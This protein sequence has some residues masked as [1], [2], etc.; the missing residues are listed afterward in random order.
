MVWWDRFSRNMFD[1]GIMNNSAT[2]KYAPFGTNYTPNVRMK[3]VGGKHVYVLENASSEDESPRKL[4][5]KESPK[6]SETT[7]T[8]TPPVVAPPVQKDTQSDEIKPP[9]ARRVVS[10]QS[11]A[12]DVPKLKLAAKEQSDEPDITS[13]RKP[14]YSSAQPIFYSV[15]TPRSDYANSH[16]HDYTGTKLH[17]GILNQNSVLPPIST[18]SPTYQPMSEVLRQENG[19]GSEAVCHGPNRAYTPSI[20]DQIPDETDLYHLLPRDRYLPKEPIVLNKGEELRLAEL[21]HRELHRIDRQKLK[22]IYIDLTHGDGRLTGFVP[23]ENLSMAFTKNQVYVNPRLLRLLGSMFLNPKERSSINYEKVLSY[24]DGG[25]KYSNPMAYRQEG[26]SPGTNRSRNGNQ[27]PLPPYAW[28]ANPNHPP[29]PEGLLH[30]GHGYYKVDPPYGQHT[31]S[32]LPPIRDRED[33]KLRR[34]VESQLVNNMNFDIEHLRQAVIEADRYCRGTLSAQQMKDISWMCGLPLQ[35]NILDRIINRCDHK[36]L[37][38]YVW[39]Q[40]LDYIEKVT[41]TRTGMFIP[42]SKRPLEYAI[43]RPTPG[44]NWPLPEGVAP[45]HSHRG[46]EIKVPREEPKKAKSVSPPLPTPPAPPAQPF[47]PPIDIGRQKRIDELEHQLKQLES[48][49]TELKKNV[50]NERKANN[51]KREQIRQQMID[52]LE[53]QIGDLD[54]KYQDLKKEQ[55]Q[56]LA[57][58]QVKKQHDL[59][60][61]AISSLESQIHNIEAKH[62]KLKNER[63]QNEAL[64]QL[65]EHDFA[66]KQLIE[67]LEAQ[68][69]TLNNRY[70]D[71]SNSR[72]L[73]EELMFT[74]SPREKNQAIADLETQ[75]RDLDSKYK[76][77]KSDLVNANSMGYAKQQEDTYIISARNLEQHVNQLEE[78]YESLKNDQKRQKEKE[79]QRQAESLH[80][81]TVQKIENQLKS[82]HSKYEGLKKKGKRKKKLG[83]SENHKRMV[84]GIED[85]IEILELKYED[86]KREKI[87]QEN[88]DEI[89][90]EESYHPIYSTLESHLIDL[91]SKYQDT[92]KRLLH[93]QRYGPDQNIDP[94]ENIPWFQR[95]VRLADALYKN[96]VDNCGYLKTDE[97]RWLTDEYNDVYSLHIPNEMIQE[98]M[99][100]TRRDNMIDI[101]QY[102]D[103]L[104]MNAK[105]YFERFRG[106]PVDLIPVDLVQIQSEP[107]PPRPQPPVVKPMPQPPPI[108]QPRPSKPPQRPPP[109]F[110]RTHS[111]SQWSTEYRQSYVKRVGERP[112]MVTPREHGN[113]LKF[114]WTDHEEREGNILPG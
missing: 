36:G 110:E 63:D 92:K 17:N 73:E 66:H 35:E 22:D 18:F 53:T 97:V 65:N 107:T 79:Q 12:V 47:A 23:F 96:D 43:E 108:P 67:K 20:S 103:I 76:D 91:Q 24:I 86:L 101:A 84:R 44:P 57:A 78:Q 50:S 13:P 113:P 34:A 42:T 30:Q 8:H 94:L 88:L 33:A 15:K 1:Y 10:E 89:R 14:V 105:E 19:D 106:T 16:R 62:E 83:Q 5:R 6:L 9:P 56:K 52:S 45:L 29:R 28:D 82:L 77:M 51:E 80:Q 40:F 72:E 7:S 98:A 61:Q 38:Q 64:G 71:L 39:Q 37:G 81:Q 70:Q 54:T 90:A 21:I 75:I 69:H 11:L 3:I 4:S 95:F 74:I 99:Q 59:Q 114:H 46:R 87:H 104:G 109:I 25:L 68:L 85:Q 58:N 26:N 111:A 60:E 55:K 93:T 100:R 41:P 2:N 31:S 48:G 49:Y 27:K 32:P 102:V 112:E